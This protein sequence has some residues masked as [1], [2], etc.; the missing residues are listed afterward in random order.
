MTGGDERLLA[1]LAGVEVGDGPEAAVAERL[2]RTGDGAVRGS[3]NNAVLVLG[4]DTRWAGRLRWSRFEGQPFLDGEPVTDHALTS[5]GLWLDRV[6]ALRPSSE[7]LMRALV[8]VAR[9]RPFHPVADWLSSLSWDGIPRLDGLLER[10]FGAEG[11]ALHRQFGRR[12]L[13]GAVAR[14]LQPGCKLDTMVVL[15]GPQ[16]GRKSSACAAMVPEPRWFSDTP[17]DLGSKD[18]MVQLQGVWMIEVAELH[19]LRRASTDAVKA[20]LSSRSDRYRPPYGRIAEDHPRQVVFVGTTNDE[21][22]LVDP[23]G[24]RRFWPVRVGRIDVQWIIAHRD[25]LWAEAVAAYQRDEPWWLDAEGE[26]ALVEQSRGHQ[27]GDAWHEVVE[28]WV[29]RQPQPFTVEQV[30]L[31]VLHV[32]VAQ[33][34]RSQRTRVGRILSLLGCEQRRPGGARRLRFWHAPGWSDAAEAGG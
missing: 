34:G 12:W 11:T 9:E 4:E 24:S 33:M 25:A 28:R 16:G 18:A 8:H 27:V 3:L 7:G 20:F 14:V 10:G 13:I 31:E 23:T 5:A 17:V 19:A 32:P 26:A 15:V 6:Y 29:A 22:F 21:E 1:R 2:D 30:L